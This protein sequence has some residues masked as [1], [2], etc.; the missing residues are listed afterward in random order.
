MENGQEFAKRRRLDD[1]DA[2]TASLLSH[3]AFSRFLD[4]LGDSVLIVNQFSGRVVRANDSFDEFICRRD[5]LAAPPADGELG[6]QSLPFLPSEGLQQLFWQEA[7]LCSRDGQ[8]RS[9]FTRVVRT[10]SPLGWSQCFVTMCSLENNLVAC[11]FTEAGD[12]LTSKRYLRWISSTIACSVMD[13]DP[14]NNELKLVWLSDRSLEESIKFG[15]NFENLFAEENGQV[16]ALSQLPL[17]A[18]EWR[19][20]RVD[21][22]MACVGQPDTVYV[23]QDLA[24]P[25][26]PQMSMYRFWLRHSSSTQCGQHRVFRVAENV[27]AQRMLEQDR[28]VQRAQLE[29]TLGHLK[30]FQT[31]V[32]QSPS[33]IG[34]FKRIGDDFQV[35]YQNSVSRKKSGLPDVLPPGLMLSGHTSPDVVQKM[36]DTARHAQALRPDPHRYELVFDIDG[37]SAIFSGIM[38]YEEDDRVAFVHVDITKQRMLEHQI[39][40]QNVELEKTVLKLKEA[41]ETKSR[42]MSV[43][44]HEIRTPLN[45]ITS[46]IALLEDCPMADEYRDIRD[47]A[48]VCSEQLLH[49]INDILELSKLQEGKM[50][51]ENTTFSPQRVLE[52][53]LDILSLE[54]KKKDLELVT[55]LKNAL[56]ELVVGDP[57]R[58]RQILVNL[59]GNSCKFSNHGADVVVHCSST[60]LP[61]GQCQLL[62]GIQDF[63]IGIAPHIQPKLFNPFQ[64]GESSQKYG[65]SGLGL[66]ISKMLA[67]LA[68][69][70]VWFETTQNVGSTFFAT[71]VVKKAPASAPEAGALS[72]PSAQPETAAPA[73]GCLLSFGTAPNATSETAA[74]ASRTA[75]EPARVQLQHAG[76]PKPRLLLLSPSEH[77]RK[78]VTQ[79]AGETGFEVET[80]NTMDAFQDSFSEDFNIVVV[81]SKLGP[82]AAA[83]VE[84][85]M[86]KSTLVKMGYSR[87]TDSNQH[88][89]IKKPVRIASLQRQLRQWCTA[90]QSATYS[91]RSSLELASTSPLRDP[92]PILVPSSMGGAMHPSVSSTASSPAS[93]PVSTWAEHSFAASSGNEAPAPAP[94][95]FDP[96]KKLLLK[97]SSEKG[98]SSSA[99]SD[100]P[101]PAAKK[102]VPR[103]PLHP[104]GR[105]MRLLIVED[106]ALNQRVL[107]MLLTRLGTFDIVIVDDGRK[108]VN[109]VLSNVVDVVF[110]DINMPELDGPTATREIRAA[111]CHQPQIVAVTANAFA[112]DRKEYMSAGMQ[113][114][115]CKPLQQNLLIEALM[116]SH[117]IIAHEHA[118]ATVDA[119]ADATAPMS[120]LAVQCALSTRKSHQLRWPTSCWSGQCSLSTLVSTGPGPA[121]STL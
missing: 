1:S 35:L 64:Q 27:T 118:E 13:L 83:D 48:K 40:Q 84:R 22:L 73:G 56:P 95:P 10:S 37:Q 121:P 109:H 70:K 77:L 88:A 102:I 44:S 117:G 89:Y 69:G 31:L 104:S 100:V 67:E 20:K 17:F 92:D 50:Q 34:L 119:T 90:V 76:M 47:I 105:P 62:F 5:S 66:C 7:T 18:P 2:P 33:C 45:G 99:A 98:P 51:L 25:V 19:A 86:P 54:A 55:D 79:H 80:L 3:D 115:L 53:S 52:E 78:C 106:N 91:V 68:G 61:N 75:A 94:E 39:Q 15:V 65:G 87:L 6:Q 97:S 8:K 108:A 107:Q 16:P 42:F 29:E 24:S 101:A 111:S 38:N 60:E 103:V 58:L 14:M 85:A 36:L 21:Q 113:R 96:P 120:I 28:E 82:F 59:V 11:T 74:D 72:E 23:E 93:K 116:Y 26:N 57:G 112:E 32:E 71:V 12:P 30:T 114:V 9:H 81:D 49:V 46:S 41:L 110:M 63:G 4:G 43:M